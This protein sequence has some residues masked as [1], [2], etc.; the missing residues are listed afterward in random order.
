MLQT[1]TL[2]NPTAW[3][4]AQQWHRCSLGSYTSFPLSS[5]IQAICHFFSLPRGGEGELVS[6]NFRKSQFRI[7]RRQT[8]SKYRQKRKELL[9]VTGY[10]KEPSG[11]LTTTWNRFCAQ[12]PRL[13]RSPHLLAARST[14]SEPASRV[15]PMHFCPS[16]KRQEETDRWQLRDN[17]VRQ[18]EREDR[19]ND[20]ETHTSTVLS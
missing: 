8:S 15:Y 1:S 16:A 14:C 9:I 2:K 17:T 18:E 20:R 7:L 19:S 3:Q 10:Y 13:P 5:R 6:C 12:A 11:T 4:T